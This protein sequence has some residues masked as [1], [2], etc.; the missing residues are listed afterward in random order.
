MGI[1]KYVCEPRVIPY[2]QELVYTKLS[3]LK[4]LEQLISK[5]KMEELTQKGVNISGFNLEN[6]TASEDRCSF[7]INPLGNVGIE[8]VEREPFR[9]IKFEGE[10]SVP[11]PVTFWVQLVADCEISCKIRLTL[12]ADLSP[13]IKMMVNGYLESGIEKLADLLVSVDYS[14]S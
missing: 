4:N 14:Q 8:I 1:E 9:T 11:F 10:K 5:E 2:S 3:N 6:F 7:K 12:H 13:M